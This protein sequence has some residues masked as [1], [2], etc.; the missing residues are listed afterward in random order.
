[1]FDDDFSN[2]LQAPCGSEY[3]HQQK[4]WTQWRDKEDGPGVEHSSCRRGTSTMRR[5]ADDIHGR[6]D[7]MYIKFYCE[8][9]DKDHV[10]RIHQHKG[11]TYLKWFMEGD[12]IEQVK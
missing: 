3:L 5:D 2:P 11:T 10:L 7:A 8:H 9:C 6:R 1:M 12:L 4:V